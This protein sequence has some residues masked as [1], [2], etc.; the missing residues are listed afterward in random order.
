M[1][2][3]SYSKFLAEH[4][5]RNLLA[6]TSEVDF[7]KTSGGFELH[8]KVRKN[9]SG[10]QRRSQHR[11]NRSTRFLN[12]G[13]SQQ[14]LDASVVLPYELTSC[15]CKDCG[16]WVFQHYDH[17]GI[18][19]GKCGSYNVEITRHLITSEYKRKCILTK[20]RLENKYKY[21]KK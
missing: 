1:E 14:R 4:N 13:K 7:V 12:C 19:C 17:N 21:N 11:F 3:R 16:R 5:F 8:F 15:F 9:K 10:K 2:E 20:E 6:K 18:Y